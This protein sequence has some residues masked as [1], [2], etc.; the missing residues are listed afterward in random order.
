MVLGV[1]IHALSVLE[2]LSSILLV[3]RWEWAPV[4][5]VQISGPSAGKRNSDGLDVFV[6]EK[7]LI[8][9]IVVAG[10]DV[11]EV[12]NVDPLMTTS[13]WAVFCR[14]SLEK[15]CFGGDGP[16][17]QKRQ[18]KQHV[19]APVDGWRGRKSG[20]KRFFGGETHARSEGSLR[21]GT[22]ISYT[23]MAP[24]LGAAPGGNY[25]RD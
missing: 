5:S 23:R 1:D 7:V 22:L 4:L 16:D 8:G 21:W 14:P 18:K 19:K 24:R 2:W 3:G 20:R 13:R 15:G 12:G 6:L 25:E 17:K 9:A 10:V 11:G